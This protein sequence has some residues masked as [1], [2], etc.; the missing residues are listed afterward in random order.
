MSA[1][2]S[3]DYE[4]VA[5][6]GMRLKALREKAKLSQSELAEALDVSRGAI[7]FY[8]NGDRIANIDFLVKVAEFFDVSFNYLLGFDESMQPVLPDHLSFLSNEAVSALIQH[9]DEAEIMNLLITDENIFQLM[10]AFYDLLNCERF[11]LHQKV[12]P[13]T[14]K[15]KTTEADK[16]CAL[17]FD[18]RYAI[19]NITSAFIAILESAASSYIYKS[20][21]NNDLA[22][23]E[24]RYKKSMQ[25]HEKMRNESI[26]IS[27]KYLEEYKKSIGYQARKAVHKFEDG[28]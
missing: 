5:F 4:C 14:G 11:R 16:F 19:F 1:V 22:A 10:R 27:Q 25:E 24:D 18:R 9:S 12:D 7:S 15:R 13:P 3:N 20:L 8:E 2:S 28:D 23:I 26:E 17:S 21:S 6:F